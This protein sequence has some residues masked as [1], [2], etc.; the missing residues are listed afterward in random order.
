MPSTK[1]QYSDLKLS[2]FFPAYNEEDNI[3]NTVE[4]AIKVLE[5]LKLKQYEVLIVNDG[6]TDKTQQIAKELEKANPHIKLVNKSNGGYGTA[7]RAGFDNASLDWIVFTDSDGQFDFSEITK[8]LDKTDGADYI[9]GYRMDR[10]D[11]L[12]RL[13]A[14]KIWALS[15]FLLFGIWVKDIDGGF[16]MMKSSGWQKISPLDST[17]GAMI[18]AEMLVKAKKNKLK[19]VQVGVHHFPRAGGNPTGVRLNVIIRSYLELFRFWWKLK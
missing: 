7:L 3:K 9:I 2:V 15:V 16:R 6:S 11:N 8:F 10:A 13:L 1:S 5:S 14:G 4:K 19:I 18:N 17:R 12:F